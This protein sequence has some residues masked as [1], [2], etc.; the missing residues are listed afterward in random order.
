MHSVRSSRGFTA[1]EA[2][3]TMAIL[4]IGLAIVAPSFGSFISSQRVKTTS[5]DLYATLMYAR[6]EAIKR[7]ADVTI[8]AVSGDWSNGWTVVDAAANV[9]RSQDAPKNKNMCVTTDGACPPSTP[10]PPTLTSLTYQLDGRLSIGSAAMTLSSVTG[11]NAVGRRCISVDTTGVPRS[12]KLGGG[13][14]C[15]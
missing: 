12:R 9:L 14:T 10:A 13:A 6:S 11:S 5:F 1:I 2:L 3:V 15:S 8:Q 7:R 4:A